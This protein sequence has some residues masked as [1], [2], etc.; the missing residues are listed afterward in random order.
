MKGALFRLATSGYARVM[1]DRT[2]AL[3]AWSRTHAATAGEALSM[4]LI[5]A[6]AG[7]PQAPPASSPLFALQAG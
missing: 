5:A 7:W 3:F 6:G 2:G 1:P 4:L